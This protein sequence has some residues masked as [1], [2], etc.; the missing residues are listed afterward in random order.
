LLLHSSI[1]IYLAVFA[2]K[3]ID[4]Y[5]SPLVRTAEKEREIAPLR[6]FPKTFY[7]LI[8]KTLSFPDAHIMEFKGEKVRAF[9][10]AG[11]KRAG[12]QKRKIAC[13]ALDGDLAL[14]KMK[15]QHGIVPIWITF[16]VSGKVL[17]RVYRD[18]RFI[19]KEG[20]YDFLDGKSLTLLDSALQPVRDFKKAKI[21]LIDV[22]G[23]TLIGANI[24]HIHHIFGTVAFSYQNMDKPDFHNDGDL[25]A[26][27]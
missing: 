22:G 3:G 4:Y 23:R 18:G 13:E 2:F 26:V 11:E 27:R 7:G 10:D 14:A 17:F 16:W 1:Y 5:N 25:I 24:S 21:Y 12:V 20:D 9:Q 19:L 15:Y 8:E 6:F